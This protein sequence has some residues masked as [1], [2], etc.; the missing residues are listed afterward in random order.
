[1]AKKS[2]SSLVRRTRHHLGLLLQLGE[3]ILSWLLGLFLRCLRLIY[4]LGHVLLVAIVPGIILF[5]VFF[6]V[7]GTKSDV[8]YRYSAPTSAACEA[9]RQNTAALSA[10]TIDNDE[11]RAI[12]EIADLKSKAALTCMLQFHSVKSAQN[13]GSAAVGLSTPYIDLDYHL[14]FL[15]FKEDGNPV[16]EGVDGKPIE[17]PQFQTLIDHL[18]ANERASKQN[19]I[20]VFVHGWRHDARIGDENVRNLRLFAAYAASFLRQRCDNEKLKKYCQAS[21]TAVYV[22]WRG[23]RINEAGVKSFFTGWVGQAIGTILGVPDL[24]AKDVEFT[25]GGKP[26][27]VRDGLL[28]VAGWI[29]TTL[30][31]T[32][33]FDRK[34]VSET[35]APS[36]IG[37]LREIDRRLVA[38]NERR[39][40]QSHRM[41]T[42]G[43]SLGGNLLATALKERMAQIV[44]SYSGNAKPDQDKPLI[45]SPIGNLIV[46]LNPASEA[47]NWITHQRAFRERA[48]L[49][50]FINQTEYDEITR[51][52]QQFYSTRQPPIYISLTSSHIWPAGGIRPSDFPSLR[53]TLEKRGINP[54]NLSDCQV[55]KHFG[56]FKLDPNYDQATY[57]LFPAFK[58]DFRPFANKLE[59]TITPRSAYC[60]NVSESS[61][62]F[63]RV[64]APIVQFTANLM[65]YFPF[66]NTNI[67]QTRT[68]GH[69]DPVRPPFGDLYGAQVAP[70]TWYGT[71]HELLIGILPGADQTKYTNSTDSRKS[72]CAIVNNWLWIART[73]RSVGRYHVNWDSGYSVIK[74]G[75][76]IWRGEDEVNLTP[77]RPRPDYT[78]DHIESQ[79]RQLLYGAGTRNITS[80]ND[81]FWNIRA[82]DTAIADHNGYANYP[83]MC[84]L[85]QFIMDDIADEAKNPGG[86]K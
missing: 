47:A 45:K 31:S 28:D 82:F 32:T 43:H 76:I 25:S 54:K 86:P 77:I 46:L 84:V 14:A 70:A 58:W 49:D 38:W 19:F 13:Q 7:F 20:I 63:L 65:R 66:M 81:P 42:I 73:K 27:T 11:L 26:I 78:F 85:F 4:R 3:T 83:L 12:D 5:F 71:T 56:D 10:E 67:E 8:A 34:P 53:K 79:I 18:E 35:I 1:M 17:A 57:E 75:K 37:A 51:L 21:V 50:L 55:A 48:N 15:E 69:V 6:Y 64:I 52:A 9:Q 29:N 44:S 68:I 61:Q 30:A 2:N 36:V 24:I 22:G 33:L 80:A 59:S 23:A 72:E 16:E 39:G 41:I 60:E 40:Q 74:N 62:L